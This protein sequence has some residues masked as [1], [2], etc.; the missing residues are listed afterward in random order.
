MNELNAFNNQVEAQRGKNVSHEAAD[1]I[2][3]YAN[4]L[5]TQLLGSLPA[6]ETC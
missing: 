5:I 1:L 3:N 2:M 4:N 6:G